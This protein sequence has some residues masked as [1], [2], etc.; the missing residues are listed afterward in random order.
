MY[1]EG[2]GDSNVA[3]A[4]EERGVKRAELF[5]KGQSKRIWAEL[6]K[7]HVRVCVCVCVWTVGRGGA[8]V[9]RDT[10]ATTFSVEAFCW[11]CVLHT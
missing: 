10:I 9:D 2:E 8:N 4:W 11:D 1:G 3:K 6:Y 7:V 5:D